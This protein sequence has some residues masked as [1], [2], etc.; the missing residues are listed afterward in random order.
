[1]RADLPT[2]L[3]KTPCFRYK[4]LKNIRLQSIFRVNIEVFWET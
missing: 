1:M 4:Y 2:R 3:A